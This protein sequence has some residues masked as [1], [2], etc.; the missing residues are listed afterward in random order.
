MPLTALFLYQ[1][2]SVSDLSPVNGMPLTRLVCNRNQIADLSPLKGMATLKELNIS[3]NPLNDLSPLAGLSLESL[4]LCDC[5]ATDVTPLAKLPLKFLALTPPRIT[6]GMDALRAIKSLE[7]IGAK[8]PLWNWTTALPTAAEFWKKYDAGEFGS[9]AR[10][11][12][13]ANK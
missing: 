4:N 6:K 3:A 1:S 2:T 9:P 12:E 13:P 11:S 10:A 5:A 7:R 8:A